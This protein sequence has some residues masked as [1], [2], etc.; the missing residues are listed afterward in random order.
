MLLGTAPT[1]S[2]PVKVAWLMTTACVTTRSSA[3][4]VWSLPVL[5]GRA[6]VA[7]FPSGLPVEKA[8]GLAGAWAASRSKAIAPPVILL[9]A[10]DGMAL[11]MFVLFRWFIVFILFIA[12][13]VLFDCLVDFVLL[14]SD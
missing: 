11:I 1:G 7:T 12:C 10:S 4:S 9:E 14:F 6:R 8:N 2:R 13:V 3:V 5:A